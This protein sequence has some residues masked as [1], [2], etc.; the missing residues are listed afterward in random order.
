MRVYTWH[1]VVC[2][3]NG[4]GS[5]NKNAK[6]QKR[7][8]KKCR[9]DG[10]GAWHMSTKEKPR[11]QVRTVFL[12][13]V[14]LRLAPA[15]GGTAAKTT[16]QRLV[17]RQKVWSTKS[18]KNSIRGGTIYLV[19]NMEGNKRG[20]DNHVRQ[21]QNKRGRGNTPGA[22]KKSTTE[23]QLT[24]QQQRQ[25]T[26]GVMVYTTTRVRRSIGLSVAL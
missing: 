15:H 21:T 9:L 13:A 22:A 12:Y 17:D 16:E 14:R 3:K 20:K 11:K 19:H 8:H 10:W 6:T 26:S 7:K 25:P 23:T 2:Y 4:I 18:K 5:R 1:T 24:N